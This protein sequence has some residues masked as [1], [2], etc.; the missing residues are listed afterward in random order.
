MKSWQ[1]GDNF[2]KQAGLIYE[3]ELIKKGYN[4]IA[5]VDEVGRGCIAGGVFAGAAI[6]PQG[7]QIN[8]VY[9]SKA[10]SEKKRNSLADEIKARAVCY[11]IKYIDN[12]YIDEQGIVKATYEA[13]RLAVLSLFIKPDVVLVDGNSVDHLNEFYC[14]FII[15]GDKHSH[16][17]A[18][19]SILAKVERDSYM[20]KLHEKYPMYGFDKHKGYG[21]K[22]HFL[23][24]EEYGLCEYHRKSFLKNYS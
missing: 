20:F 15:G 22:A 10:L 13:M 18:A 21:T 1:A 12:L 2:L 23:A 4:I 11:S 19:A 5:G 7:L 6:L 14:K 9:D 24:L 3:N 17:I 8:G 16:I